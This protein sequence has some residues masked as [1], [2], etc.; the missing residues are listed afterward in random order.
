MKIFASSA[1]PTLDKFIGKELWIRARV[2]LKYGYSYGL[3]RVL[4]KQQETKTSEKNPDFTWEET[5]Y[6]FNIIE[7]KR[8]NKGNVLV[9]T[10]EQMNYVLD[11]PVTLGQDFIKLFYPVECV[12]TEEIFELTDPNLTYQE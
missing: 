8:L 5:T 1:T 12:T 11:H 6:T 2:K 10:Q 4:S 7:M 9:C 3:I